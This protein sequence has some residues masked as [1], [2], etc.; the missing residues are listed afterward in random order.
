MRRSFA[1]A[2][3]AAA[4]AGAAVS[5]VASGATGHPAVSLRSTPLGS[6]LVAGNGRTL[7]LFTADRKTSACTGPCAALWPPLLAKGSPTAGAGVKSSLLGTVKRLDGT[8]Q[9]TY[10]GHPLYFFAPDAR[11]GQTK[12]EGIVHF[13]GKW[14]VLSPLGMKVVAVKT[15]GGT[16]VKPPT[17][18]TNSNGGYG[19]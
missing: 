6:V 19:K 7:Y 18:T 14:F 13:G 1:V 16:V 15:S 10:A 17:T 3:L 5:A 11:A 2:V 8:R 9:V 4:L 12:G